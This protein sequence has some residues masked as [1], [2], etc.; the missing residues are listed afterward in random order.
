MQ[1]TWDSAF[2]TPTGLAVGLGPKAGPWA[3]RP[4]TP[5]CGSPVGRKHRPF[6]EIAVE[7]SNGIVRSHK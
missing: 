6:G 2:S 1:Q 7:L 3:V 4:L 5:N